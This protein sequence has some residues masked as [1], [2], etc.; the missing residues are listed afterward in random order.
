MKQVTF[1]SDFGTVDS[2]V[3]EVKG[4]IRGC[5]PDVSIIDITHWINPG[6]ITAASFVLLTACR[7]FARETVH[8]V[9][10]DP[11]VGS[12]RDIIAVKTSDYTF[13]GPDNG[14][15]FESVSA[16][17]GGLVYTLEKKRFL[18]KIGK[19]YRGNLV[20]ERILA[21]GVS[22]T[23]HGRD[24]FAP[25]T[26]YVLGKNPLVEVSKEKESMVE[27]VI[28]R[29]LV[30]EDKISG[31]VVYI[32]RFGNLIT[33]IGRDLMTGHDEVFLKTKKS[34]TSVGVLKSSY[35]SIDEGIPLPLI[36]SR[37]FLEIA[38]NCGNAR[39]LFEASYGDE[40]LIL[41]QAIKR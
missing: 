9:V 38:V 30:S 33:N 35:S 10:V 8:L 23:F 21:E 3:G 6:N 32:D 34:I 1:T 31:E 5:D 22:S 16:A 19:L 12:E 27:H 2:Y 17:G 18:E 40:I 13:I 37:G 25:L 20:L 15:L 7:Y 26:A 24:L 28:M 29:P 4:V 11:G 39:E 41:K 36:G 14:V